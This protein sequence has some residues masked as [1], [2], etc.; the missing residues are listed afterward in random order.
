MNKLTSL[1]E[2]MGKRPGFW[3]L[4]AIVL[5]LVVITP[6]CGWLFGCGCDWPWR[7]FIENCNAFKPDAPEKCPWCV[8]SAFDLPALFRM[9][10]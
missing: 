4:L 7:G 2:T 10:W 1:S 6:L 9:V 3:I 8:N 5:T